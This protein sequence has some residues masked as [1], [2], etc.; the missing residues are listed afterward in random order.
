MNDS[1]SRRSAID[2]VHK[3]ICP[4]V[5]ILNEDDGEVP[6]SEQDKMVLSINKD[7][8]NALKALP[9]AG[10]KE[11]LDKIVIR[12]EEIG[13]DKGF[14]DGYA[15][16]V[17]DAEP[18]RKPDEWCTDCKEYDHDKHCC[19]RFNRVIWSALQDAELVR[20]RDCKW[21]NKH[22]CT[23]AVELY[24]HDNDFCSW[25]ERRTE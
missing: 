6:M 20:C 10:P 18:V 21:K 9:S 1:I 7:I 17:T 16:A 2:T 8:C 25:A 13:Y 15:Q 14:R 24:I 22:H 12:H 11:S 23:R 3:I 5:C 4:Y 19:P